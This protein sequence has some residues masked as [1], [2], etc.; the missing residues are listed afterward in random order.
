M[1]NAT[2]IGYIVRNRVTGKTT[3]YKSGVKASEAADRAD[4]A[5][6][7]ICARRDAVWSDQP[8]RITEFNKAKGIAS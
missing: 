6:G 7:A 4:M 2:I 8:H 5:Y 3:A 1:S